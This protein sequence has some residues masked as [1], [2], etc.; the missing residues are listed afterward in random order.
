LN[1]LAPTLWIGIPLTVVTLLLVGWKLTSGVTDATLTDTV[2]TENAEVTVNEVI[3]HGHQLQ[4]TLPDNGAN[5]VPAIEWPS[6]E[7]AKTF[8]YLGATTMIDPVSIGVGIEP[9]IP[10]TYMANIDMAAKYVATMAANGWTVEGTFRTA[11]YVDV[12]LASEDM[13]CRVIALPGYMKLLYPIPS[14]VP[15]PERYING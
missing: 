2:D 6:S 11:E 3:A 4:S 5:A 14:G 12:Y 15:D 13:M 8:E 10:Y 1:K 7:P 9:D